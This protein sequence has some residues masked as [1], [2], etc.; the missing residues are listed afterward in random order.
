LGTTVKG[1]LMINGATTPINP[2]R[3]NSSSPVNNV[4][5]FDLWVDLDIGGKTVRICNWSETPI[6]NP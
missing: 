1:P 6:F 3:Y 2:F 5:K 4:D